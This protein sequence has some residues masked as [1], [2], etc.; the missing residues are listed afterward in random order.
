[1]SAMSLSSVAQE[2]GGQLQGEAVF[3]VVS[4]DTRTIEPGA[5]YVALTGENFNGNGFVSD[6][7]EK[8]A[9]AALVS[10]SPSEG[11][12]HINVAADHMVAEMS[13]TRSRGQ[14]HVART[15]NTK[16]NQIVW[17]GS[18]TSGDDVG[19]VAHPS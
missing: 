17:H 7:I 11:I 15:D 14:T 19:H 3:N 6:A 10:E 16:A 5:L 13:K 1:M 9:V 12:A 18:E 2:T 8:G 4:T